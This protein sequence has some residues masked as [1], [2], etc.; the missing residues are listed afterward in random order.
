MLGVLLIDFYMFRPFFLT[1][2]GPERIP[3]EAGHHAHES[4]GTMTVP[5]DGAGLRFDGR[6]G[7]F[8]SGRTVSPASSAA[9]PSLAYLASAGGAH[10]GE[11]AEHWGIGVMSTIVTVVSAC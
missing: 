1:F 5:A 8:R 7:V 11:A 6:G 3:P 2:Y 9:T 10:R 4:P